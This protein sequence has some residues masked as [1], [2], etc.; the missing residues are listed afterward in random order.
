MS[1]I[2]WLSDR[3]GLG[4][5]DVVRRV[6][7][8]DAPLLH[9]GYWLRVPDDVI[10]RI[11][12]RTGVQ[13]N[14]LRGL[15]LAD[16]AAG[17]RADEAPMRFSGRRFESLPP[18]KRRR[19]LA[20]CRKCVGRDAQP[21]VRLMWLLDWVAICPQDHTI[22]TTHCPGCSRRMRLPALGSH[23]TFSPTACHVCGASIATATAEAA[24]PPV[25]RLQERMLIGKRTGTIALPGI[26]ILT[27]SEFMSI[28]DVLLGMTW[29][30]IERRQLEELLWYVA[31]DW[32]L[33]KGEAGSF[34]ERRYG[35]LA[36]LAWLLEGW[37]VSANCSVALCLLSRWLSMARGPAPDVHL[38]TRWAHPPEEARI[39]EPMRDRIRSL[40]EATARMHPRDLAIVAYDFTRAVTH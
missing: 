25:L 19:S 39:Q 27:W 13:A 34:S 35:G 21:Y 20:V 14:I 1:W 4:I 9:E 28:A 40:V 24:H 16:W 33:P 3:I 6:L 29:R 23:T 7:A 32:P 11:A 8:I 31:Q 2:Y 26:G 36:L 17:T 12:A 30:A 15:T 5:V 10:G 37:P 22:L 18:N 38:G